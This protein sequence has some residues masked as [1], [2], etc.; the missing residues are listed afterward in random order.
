MRSI[1]SRPAE[2]LWGGFFL[3]R[4]GACASPLT[5][6]LPDLTWRLAKVVF[7]PTYGDPAGLEPS[8]SRSAQESNH[9][10]QGQEEQESEHQGQA[11]G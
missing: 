1:E 3:G 7:Y 8:P 11:E 2:H 4:R 5:T 10:G 6:R 9:L